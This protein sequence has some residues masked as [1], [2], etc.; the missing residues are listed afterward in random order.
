MVEVTDTP[1]K[2]LTEI[3]SHKRCHGSAGDIAFRT[4]LLKKLQTMGAT[5]TVVEQGCVLVSIGNPEANTLF[6]CHVDTVHSFSESNTGYQQGLFYDPGL[7]QIFVADKAKSSCL[8]A[9]DGAGVYVLL[10]LIEAKVDGSYLFH[11]GEEKGGIG[12]NAILAARPTWLEKF[13]RAIAFDRAG[14]DEVIATQGG[15]LCASVASAKELAD[16]L[17]ALGLPHKV[18]HN[19]SFTDTKVYSSVIPECFNVSVGYMFQHTSDEYLDVPHLEALVAAA[20]KLDWKTLPTV[21]KPAP[22]P[23]F[24]KPLADFSFEPAPKKGKFPKNHWNEPEPVYKAPPPYVP[25]A[26]TIEDVLAWD[27]E[28]IAATTDEDPDAAAIA[29]KLL[30]VEVMAERA[31]TAALLNYI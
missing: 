27:T 10:K 31:K 6:S 22:P 28:T 15:R 30:V 4:W 9:D 21:R 19:G 5:P 7:E 16:R 1:N 23:V 17:T 25:E 24:Q 3:L 14:N 18:S 12:S 8:G 13:D 20:I 11:T 2:M 29:I 26:I